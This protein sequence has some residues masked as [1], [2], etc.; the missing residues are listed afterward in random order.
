M[1]APYQLTPLH[2]MF[3]FIIFDTSRLVCVEFFVNDNCVK[4]CERFCEKAPRVKYLL[5]DFSI[6]N[7]EYR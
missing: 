2:S 7:P 6:G 4:K 1:L 3:L 5:F